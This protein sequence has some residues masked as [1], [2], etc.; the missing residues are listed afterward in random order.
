MYRYP[1]T[2]FTRT[3][4]GYL[5]MRHDRRRVSRQQ[6]DRLEQLVSDS[7][8][9]MGIP[10]I[11]RAL[12]ARAAFVIGKAPQDHP[13]TSHAKAGIRADGGYA[14]GGII[15][16]DLSKPRA[17]AHEIGHWLYDMGRVARVEGWRAWRAI[18]LPR[19]NA[20]DPLQSLCDRPG[21]WG[22]L[23]RYLLRRDEIWSRA[24]EQWVAYRAASLRRGLTAVLPVGVLARQPAYWSRRMWGDLRAEIGAFA[25]GAAETIVAKYVR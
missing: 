4:Q 23:K 11:Q 2:P 25:R 16:V 10:S 9:V 19:M 18:A 15:L 24:F 22:H 17:F 13:V 7:V 6:A 14:K 3:D 12:E 8:V 21:Q 1:D 20:I 5:V